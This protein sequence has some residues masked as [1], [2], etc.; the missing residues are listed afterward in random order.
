MSIRINHPSN[1]LTGTDSVTIKVEGGTTTV[2]KSLRFDSSSVVFPNKQLPSGEAGA[3]VFDTSSKSLKYHNGS[4][5]VE[6]LSQSDILAPVN[7]SLANIYSELASRV[8]TVSYSSSQIPS[9]SISGTN[10]FISFPTGSGGT[11]NTTPGLYTAAPQGSIMNYSLISGQTPDS[12]REQM[13][14]STG[15]QSGRDGSQSNP[16]VTS[17][18]WCY[19]DGTYWRWNGPNGAVLVQVP[20]LNK[21]AYM[22]AMSTS[23]ITKT[24]SVI[25]ATGTV[26]GT[27]LTVDQLPAHQ[28][29]FS[30]VTN[31]TGDHNHSIGISSQIV[32]P[33]AN[34]NAYVI[35]PGG[36][37]Y[38]NV[39]GAHQHSFSGYT[40]WL[41]SGNQHN[42]SI[43]NADVDHFNV[44]VL[45]NIAQ[46][47]IAL[48]QTAGDSRYVL[49]SGDTMT[50]A[51]TIANSATIT[52]NDTNLAYWLRTSTGTERAA[53]YHNSTDNTLRLRSSGGYDISITS[54]G[55][56]SANSLVSSTSITGSTLSLTGN[57]TI[58]GTL[59][60]GFATVAGIQINGSAI[61]GT[62]Y[63]GLSVNGI[64]ADNTG[65]ITV[66]L[67]TTSASLNANG[68]WW[69]DNTTGLIKQWGTFTVSS[70]TTYV[71]FPTAFPTKCFNIQITESG[72]ATS[73]SYAAGN[74]S[75]TNFQ[76]TGSGTGTA[77]TVYWEA[78]GY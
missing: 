41:G 4:Q 49:K 7:I 13:G 1:T 45:Y 62:K 67:A 6:I 19:A 68:G 21:N 48:N 66:P 78:T 8:E 56:L 72:G 15:S 20:N 5:W 77:G 61:V 59:S 31:V 47:A 38:T 36:S 2:P 39:A 9:A 57:A 11:T 34:T 14:G 50:G 75:T 54:A 30:G 76:I 23:G 25:A 51:L 29:S 35:L 17:T 3:V 43:L 46:P 37:L 53:M 10:L 65:N 32:Q 16:Y 74:V 44:A 22:K 69:K 18:G 40:N 71:T 73:V 24:D 58:T 28:F 60:S 63:V 33:N 26:S 55:Q 12:I 70:S 27:S 64:N 42:H 52:S